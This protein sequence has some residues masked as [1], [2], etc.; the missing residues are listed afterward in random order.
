MC[1]IFL[2]CTS[3]PPVSSQIHHPPGGGTSFSLG[4]GSDDV[5]PPARAGGRRSAAD[6]SAIAAAVPTSAPSPLAP[7][8]WEPASGRR[9]AA[10][11]ASL[12]EAAGGGHTAGAHSPPY[13][14]GGRARVAGYGAWSE[15]NSV[16]APPA[17]LPAQP[18]MQ[19][20]SS[21][22]YASGS[23]QNA[24]NFLTDRRTT[25]VLAHPGGKSSIVFG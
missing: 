3:F 7:S 18:A 4:W 15:S 17:A 5:P 2:D 6:C 9:S 11:I 10:T 12:G 23:N 19:P 24:G 8:T 20:V 14:G 1:L 16:A 13:G 22:S 21:N 25:R